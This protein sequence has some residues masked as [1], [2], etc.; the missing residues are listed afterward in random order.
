[1]VSSAIYLPLL[2]EIS[3]T[4]SHIEDVR[5]KGTCQKAQFP[6]CT[7]RMKCCFLKIEGVFS[8]SPPW[9]EFPKSSSF[10]DLLFLCG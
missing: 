7:Q 6:V 2:C 9:K 8:D 5:K 4:T 10:S 1:M 3:C